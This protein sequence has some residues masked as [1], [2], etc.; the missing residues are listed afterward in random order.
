MIIH[1][2]IARVETKSI[3]WHLGLPGLSVS[4]DG[5]VGGE[6]DGLCKISFIRDSSFRRKVSKFLR[7]DAI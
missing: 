7:E 5:K 6:I 4:L 2:N 1:E 3:R